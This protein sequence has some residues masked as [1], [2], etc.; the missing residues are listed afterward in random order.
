MPLEFDDLGLRLIGVGTR[1]LQFYDD[2]LA[3]Q[4]E[5]YLQADGTL[6]IQGESGDGGGVSGGA[7]T[8]AI[9]LV[10]SMHDDLSNARVLV[11]GD[12]LTQIDGGARN[13]YTL[14]VAPGLGLEIV[15]DLV[16]INEGA[17]LT[18]TA[19]QAIEATLTAR[20]IMPEATDAYDLG[21][22]SRLWRRGYLSELEAF[23]MVENTI[24]LVGGWLVVPHDQGSLAAD[25]AAADVTIDFGKAMTPADWVQMRGL[26]QVEYLLVG[27]LSGGTIYNVTR[28]V[29]GSGAN[30]WPA[31]MAFLVMGAAGDGRIEL[32]SAGPNIS[33][34]IQ[35]A[36]YNT[37]TEPVTI[38]TTGLHIK[39]VAPG[40]YAK[41]YAY[42]MRDGATV[43]GRLYALNSAGTHTVYLQSPSVA[44][45]NSGL[46]LD[47]T[48]PVG[49]GA[50]IELNATDS[51]GGS[52]L[53][54]V[55]GG[56]V[57]LGYVRATVPIFI[58]DTA[59]TFQTLG[60]TI[61]QGANDD[62][63]IAL[64]SSDVA[65]GITDIT[66]T[67]TFARLLKSGADAGG[68]NLGGFTEDEVGIALISYVTN[69]NTTKTTAGLGA[70]NI[71]PRK[72]SGT[73]VA[74]MG[75]D[76]NLVTIR[77]R[78][79]TRFIFDA[80]GSAHA[81]IEWTTFDEHDDVQV[82]DTLEETMLAWQD[83]VKAGFGEFLTQQ[84]VDL[85]KLGIVHFDEANPGHAMVNTTRLSMLLVGA[86]R[87][88][89]ERVRT[90]ERWNVGTL[91][92]EG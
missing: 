5:I 11:A 60:L 3:L 28:N 55:S 7:P 72:K 81:D 90:L 53:T 74:D 69:D 77:N 86:I 62:E 65:H 43:N 6:N 35:G 44:A 45:E 48:A 83:P 37:T 33:V 46:H 87:Q 18:W 67:D 85:E 57:G 52:Q 2:N 14:S 92:L 88:M 24:S 89:S 54:V 25:A 40:S 49:F 50:S 36:A 34:I 82:L 17:A 56:L 27:A 8:D 61:N 64:K 12:G 78:N 80:E 68:L 26:G 1:G 20:D 42:T 29:D 58:N 91:K 23:V 70:V 59:N 51:D 22:S 15:D 16:R 9:Y 21:S 84:R 19:A 75:A 63:M 71:A 41:Q 31:G 66:E 30:D 47:S 32:N 38:D 39:S 10:L 13:N 79:T 4:A 76:A 73:G